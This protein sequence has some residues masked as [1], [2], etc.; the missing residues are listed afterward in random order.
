MLPKYG[1]FDKGSE[2]KV[3]KDLQGVKNI[4]SD[5][6]GFTY[7]AGVNAVG[8]IDHV[9]VVLKETEGKF[10]PRV[11]AALKKDPNYKHV[12]VSASR[13]GWEREDQLREHFRAFGKSSKVRIVLLDA[14]KTWSNTKFADW[15]WQ[16]CNAVIVAIPPG[17]T[18]YIQPWDIVLFRPFKCYWRKLY[19]K[20]ISGHNKKTYMGNLCKPTRSNLLDWTVQSTNHLKQNH[21]STA[22]K[23]FI[24]V[25]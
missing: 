15:L 11:L 22:V 14:Y 24:K 17:F 5:K 19:S 10:G 18:G 6:I 13:S 7:C 9:C 21:R 1:Y 4:K 16:T 23:G 2:N 20:W 8:D 25:T 3:Q 12:T